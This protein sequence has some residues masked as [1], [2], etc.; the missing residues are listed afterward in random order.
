MTNGLPR[1]G[2]YSG[3][4]F[5][6]TDVDGTLLRRN[7]PLPPAVAE[8]A[9]RYTALGGRLALCT[10]RSLPAAEET[11][12][13]L[14]V[15]GPSVLCGGAALYDFQSRRDLDLRPLPLEVMEILRALL[16]QAPS[17]S[18][19]ALTE[20]TSYVLRRNRRL[21]AAGVPEENIGPLRSVEEVEGPVL[22][23]TLCCEEPAR[24]EACRR[25]FPEGRYRFTFASRSFV[26]VVAAG[27]AKGDALLR[28][29]RLVGIPPGR[30]LCAGDGLTDLPMLELAGY[31]FAPENAAAA[32]RAAADRV[33]PSVEQGGMALAFAEAARMLQSLSGGK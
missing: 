18:V 32:V 33:V 6:L 24:L 13:R 2:A 1:G 8:A 16:V 22:K 14:G 7:V 23:L 11:A 17:V 4:C 30:F 21:N 5:F 3:A 29:A 27:A 28:L 31:A 19:Q 20:K 9:R 12:R 26:D 25:F 10:G 15:N